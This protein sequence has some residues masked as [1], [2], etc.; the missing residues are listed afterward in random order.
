MEL[1]IIEETDFKPQVL[2]GSSD[3]HKDILLNKDTSIDWEDV[4]TGG[5][6]SGNNV[7]DFHTDLEH[8]M[9]IN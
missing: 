8:K 6:E 7:K 2:G 9:G 1:K 5:L 4:Y 3:I